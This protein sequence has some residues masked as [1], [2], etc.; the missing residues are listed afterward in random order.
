MQI[1]SPLELRLP[2]PTTTIRFRIFFSISTP[3][4]APS[5]SGRQSSNGRR[6]SCR[7][8]GPNTRLRSGS[9]RDRA[10]KTS[11]F[12]F[13]G[14]L[15]DDPLSEIGTSVAFPCFWISNDDL[16][17]WI[18]TCVALYSLIEIYVYDPYFWTSIFSRIFVSDPDFCL[19]RI[20]IL[21]LL[22]PAAS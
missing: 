17:F 13:Q 10:E 9:R 21:L 12:F 18:E 1:F 4:L 15:G 7:R 6:L 2:T 8:D 5:S 22:L 3:F 19:D 14:S 16:Y 20:R 11:R